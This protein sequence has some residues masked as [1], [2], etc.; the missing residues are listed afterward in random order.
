MG[1]AACLLPGNPRKLWVA[2]GAGFQSDVGVL[3]K[4]SDGGDSWSRVEMGLKLAHVPFSPGGLAAALD[5][6]ATTS[7]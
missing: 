4:S 3:L 6:L 1:G 5:H 7:A 2:A